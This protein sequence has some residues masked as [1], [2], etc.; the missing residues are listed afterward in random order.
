MY[1]LIP[2]IV[3]VGRLVDRLGLRALNDECYGEPAIEPSFSKPLPAN[4]TSLRSL[5]KEDP[6]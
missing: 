4:V 3:D 2:K 5:K 1:L 6:V